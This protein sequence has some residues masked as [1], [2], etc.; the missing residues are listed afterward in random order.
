MKNDPEFMDKEF[1]SEFFGLMKD[2][3]KVYLNE[4][5]RKLAE[6][7]QARKD[8][9]HKV[10]LAANGKS[11]TKKTPKEY[12]TSMLNE[13]FYDRGKRLAW[14]RMPMMSNKPS[15]EYIRFTRYATGY[16]DIITGFL[17][18]TAMQEILRIADVLDRAERIESGLLEPQDKTKFYDINT[19]YIKDKEK[20]HTKRELL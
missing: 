6:E 15:E 2:G 3:K 7:E 1:K 14:Y 20:R 11:Y 17:V 9:E 16:K 4:W 13:Y 5:Q 19:S 12:A 10:V 18:N 8:F